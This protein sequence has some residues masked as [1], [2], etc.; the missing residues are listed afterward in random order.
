MSQRQL[1]PQHTTNTRDESPFSLQD[2]NRRF[3]QSNCRRP[4]PQTSR[5]PGSAVIPY[6]CDKRQCKSFSFIHAKENVTRPLDLTPPLL[7]GPHQTVGP[8]TSPSSL[9]PNRRQIFSYIDVCAA[10][11]YGHSVACLDF[12]ARHRFLNFLCILNIP[13]PPR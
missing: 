12:A 4:K 9:K 5:P 11:K 13:T 6:N 2:S 8:W 7:S 1:P 10:L 3:K